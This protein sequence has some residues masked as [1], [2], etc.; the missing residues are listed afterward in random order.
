MY[1]NIAVKILDLSGRLINEEIINEKS[2]IT[3]NPD[4]SESGVYLVKITTPES[5]IVKQLVIQK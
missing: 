4:I 1:E 5:R 3:I 2:S